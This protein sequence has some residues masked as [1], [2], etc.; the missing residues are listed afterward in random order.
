VNAIRPMGS[1]LGRTQILN[2]PE[3]PCGSELAR[4]GYLPAT[5]DIA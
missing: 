4:D 5:I 2:S 3:I 1:R